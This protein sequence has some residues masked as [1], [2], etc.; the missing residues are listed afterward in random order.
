MGTL[1]HCQ[2]GDRAYE[3]QMKSGLENLERSAKSHFQE[4]LGFFGDITR[5]LFQDSKDKATLQQSLESH[6]KRGTLTREHLAAFSK[7]ESG[8]R[9]SHDW[10]FGH[11]TSAMRM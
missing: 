8:K 2:T 3:Q 11:V 10:R 4:L 7:S 6:L 9:A 1:V 5:N